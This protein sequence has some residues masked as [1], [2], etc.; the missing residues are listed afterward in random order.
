MSCCDELKTLTIFKGFNTRFAG[1]PLVTMNFQSEGLDLTGFKAYFKLCG[2]TKEYDDI[3]SPV[4]V[5]FTAEE[6]GAFPV[7]LNY[8]EI[9]VED[10]NGN[11]HPFSTAIPCNVVEWT[12]GDIELSGFDAT[13]TTEIQE[14]TI[15][16][17]FENGG[18][19]GTFNHNELLNRDLDNQHPISAITGLEE[20]L[21]QKEGRAYVALDKI[22]PYLYNIT[23]ANMD[24]NFAKDYFLTKKPE[25]NLGACSTVR[26]GG[27][28]DV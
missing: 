1:R 5:D 7:G 6:T 22:K 18:G 3:T 27:N 14:N 26:N 10:F 12:E 28:N 23:Y 20:E 25:I 15:I 9:I 21:R 13:I 2:V 19:S 11:K 16:I 4:E 17:K 24:Y 8:A